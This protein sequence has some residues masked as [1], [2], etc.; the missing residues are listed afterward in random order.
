V[1][2]KY[3]GTDGI[4][5]D[6]ESLLTDEFVERL[7]R[8]ALQVLGRDGARLAIIR[9]TRASGPRIE[10]ALARGAAAA[11]ANVK[12]AGVLPTPA[13]VVLIERLGFD[14]V[15]VVSASHNPFADN[16]IKFF[17]PGG[18]KLT[19]EVES[20]IEAALEQP[21]ADA[22]Q[23]GTVSELFGGEDDYVRALRERFAGLDLSG[24]RIAL[25]TANGATY[26]VAPRVFAEL[27][28]ELVVTADRPDGTNINQDCGSTHAETL[29]AIV[30][31]GGFDAGFAFDGDG[32]RLVAV[33]ADGGVV[34]GDEIIAIA[35][36]HLRAAGRLPGDGVAVTVMTNYGFHNAM[37]EAGIEVAV[38]DV[39]DRYVLEA[40]LERDWALG[41]EQSGHVIDRGFVA[42]GDGT[43]SA[44]LLLEAMQA[45]GLGLRESVP[46]RRLP[47]TLRNVPVRDR[48]EVAGADAVWSAVDAANAALEGRGRVLV[49]PSGTE[50]LVRVMVEAPTAEEADSLC[51]QL[52]TLIHDN[53]SSPD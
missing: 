35:A 45:S 14:V 19:D 1:A 27:G 5:G 29:A 30:G 40:L 17:G 43:A 53:L 50:P 34:D 31:E 37:Q 47:Q 22:G 21:A 42:T 2:H 44:L 6:A 10:Q 11:G 33:D 24:R 41:G 46:M 9:D 23:P 16:G 32:D 39:G 12:L 3:F 13:A 18:L 49:R 4:R 52:A 51:D 28:A 48:D 7:A 15:A 26:R 8:A 38:T 20:Q 36:T 25:D